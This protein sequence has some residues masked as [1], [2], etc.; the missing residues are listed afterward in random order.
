MLFL[1]NKPDHVTRMLALLSLALHCSEDK[2][3]TPT[4]A[5]VPEVP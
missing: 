3:Q 4:L 1:K 5:Y 2:V